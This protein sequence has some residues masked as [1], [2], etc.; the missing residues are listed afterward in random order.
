VGAAEGLE[1]TVV[2]EEAPV[3]QLCDSGTTRE[4]TLLFQYNRNISE[5][6][7]TCDLQLRGLRVI[8]SNRAVIITHVCFYIIVQ[9]V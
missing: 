6:N 3:R 9:N 1:A 8:V 4:E 5:S 2:W 7:N